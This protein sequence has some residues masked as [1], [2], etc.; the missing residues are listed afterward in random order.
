M[1]RFL[2]LILP[3]TLIHRVALSFPANPPNP[4][5]LLEERNIVVKAIS[6]LQYDMVRF[7]VKPGETI[8][9]TL[10]NTD[11]MAHN[12]LITQ[13]GQREAVVGLAAAME[14]N[15]PAKGYV[16]ETDKVLAAIPVLKPGEQQSI[17]FKAPDQEGVFPYVCTYPG[18]GLVMYGA[19]YVT[20]SQLPPLT[21]DLNVPPQRR[22]AQ[23]TT[24]AKESGHPWP[25][26]LPTMYRT[27][28]PESG[29]ASVAVG[30]MG[31]ISYCWDAAQCRLRYAWKGGFLD[32]TRHWS[33]KGKELADI[34]GVV[35]YRDHTEFP[36][37][38][39]EKDYIPEVKYMGYIME[40]RYPTFKYRLDSVEVTER[41]IPT[42]EKPG[43]K[44]T[45]S[46]KNLDKSLWF[47]KDNTN[48]VN[49]YSNRG[50]WEG[51][52]LKLSPEEAQEFTITITE[53]TEGI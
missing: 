10:I 20:N 42:F 36:F 48:A 12:M 30:M 9:I 44:R 6:G 46:F 3:I 23:E 8:K 49:Y 25:S 22:D 13:P 24:E 39:G 29:P 32:L 35:F 2:I 47:F 11:E 33:G 37:R 16:P 53:K 7:V 15:G 51:N 18:H 31:N 26:I 41:I 50:Q 14:D 21:T 45:L 19:L 52:Y 5:N 28:M 1:L 38:I 40:N 27:F 43:F 34:V 4:A 17:L